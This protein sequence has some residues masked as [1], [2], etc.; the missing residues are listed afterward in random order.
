MSNP[1]YQSRWWKDHYF[2]ASIAQVVAAIA[3]VVML[4]LSVWQLR[5][6]FGEARE[7]RAEADAQRAYEERM[8]LATTTP[9]LA[10]DKQY[11]AIEVQITDRKA[12]H[13]K[14]GTLD[15]EEILDP[16]K[17]AGL[18]RRKDDANNPP[19]TL[20][21]KNFGTGPALQCKVKFVTNYT[22]RLA[23]GNEKLTEPVVTECTVDPRNLMPGQDA[24]ILGFP[25]CFDMSRECYDAQGYIVFECERLDGTKLEFKETFDMS[26]GYGAKP[27]PVVKV[28]TWGR[29]FPWEL[30]EK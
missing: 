30:D 23:K 26:Q 11:R 25:S 6:T 13:Y 22:N 20:V 5:M 21:V 8:L 29:E 7:Q 15:R 16:P 3:A 28:N 14:D 19:S 17:S 18:S 4:G 10:C 2:L 9:H 24:R 12:H 27:Y 1:E